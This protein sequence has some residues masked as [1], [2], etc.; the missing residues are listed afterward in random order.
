MSKRSFFEEAEASIAEIEG[1]IDSL[2]EQ[3]QALARAPRSRK[4]I[5]TAM[6]S[7]L[8]DTAA[9]GAEAINEKFAEAQRKD[10][11]AGHDLLWC[12]ADG[13][14]GDVI[15]W[16]LQKE[17]GALIREKCKSLPEGIDDDERAARLKAVQARLDELRKLRD[18]V[19]RA[20]A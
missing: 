10:R 7:V 17:L 15:T 16:L 5:E 19:Q 8:I 2:L 3:K 20:A 13:A 14:D 11:P 1:E 12:G 4:Q 18:R 9:R 6:L